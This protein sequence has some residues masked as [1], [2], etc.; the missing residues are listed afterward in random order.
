MEGRPP[1]SATDMSPLRPTSLI[2]KAREAGDE[3]VA[4]K[5]LPFVDQP[6]FWLVQSS[7]K[8]KQIG[9][10]RHQEALMDS[11][12]TI[13]PYLRVFFFGL[14]FEQFCPAHH[15]SNSAFSI[16]C[17]NDTPNCEV[18]LHP[19]Q[20]AETIERPNNPLLSF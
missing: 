18:S 3:S 5:P 1:P 2:R 14:A 6:R 4:G 11:W 17:Q 9:V 20:V 12:D 15:R 8:F 13:S 10:Q 16:T 7:Q 19:Q